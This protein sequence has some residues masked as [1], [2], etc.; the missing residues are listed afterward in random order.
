MKTGI[1]LS[2]ILN[3]ISYPFSSFIPDILNIMIE[4]FLC[5]FSILKLWNYPIIYANSKDRL[6]Q[7][8]KYTS[9]QV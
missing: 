5:F 7:V 4:E 8:F 2:H 3:L 9:I 1:S 6:C